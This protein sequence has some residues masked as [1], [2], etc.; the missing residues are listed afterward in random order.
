[1]GGMSGWY[2]SGCLATNASCCFCILLW[3]CMTICFHDRPYWLGWVTGS[4]LGGPAH[5]CLSLVQL[6]GPLAFLSAPAQRGVGIADVVHTYSGAYCMAV[7][8]AC[9]ALFSTWLQRP[10]L[11]NDMCA[12]CSVQPLPWQQA[13]TCM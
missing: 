1:V 10:Y 11:P 8:T 6:L 5:C 12:C 2:V 9:C 4:N 13:H 3:S 7:A